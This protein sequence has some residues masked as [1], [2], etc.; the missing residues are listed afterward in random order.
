MVGEAGSRR[1]LLALLAVY[2]ALASVGFGPYITDDHPFRQT[3]TALSASLIHGVGDLWRYELP[4][5]GPP[6]VV[7]F[8]FPLYQG[9]AKA[10]SA[11]AGL[12]LAMAGR[13]VG[14]T[15]LLLCLWPLLRMARLLGVAWPAIVL[16]PVFLAPLYVFWSRAF[17]IET[18]ALLFAL[19]YLSLLLEMLLTRRADALRAAALAASGSLAALV[20]VTTVFPLVLVGAAATA[21]LAWQW[22]R[23]R[24][25]LALPL[26]LALAHLAL[27]AVALAWLRHADA[28]KAAHP[29]AVALTSQALPQWNYGPLSQRIDPAIWFRLVNNSTDMIF[30]LPARLAALKVALLAAFCAVFGFFLWHCD[31]R[32]RRQVLLMAGLFLLPFLI[33]TNLHRIHNYY[34]AANGVF[35]L[36]G[37]G[38]AAHGALEHS[39]R[40][41]RAILSAYLGTLLALCLSCLWYFQHKSSQRGEL[42]EISAALR[43]QTAADAILIISG[44]DWS[45]VIPYQAQRR[46]LMLPTFVNDAMLRNSAAAIRAAGLRVGAYVDCGAAPDRRVP[47]LLA[48]LGLRA[49]GEARKLDGCSLSL[50]GPSGT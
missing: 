5:L 44:Q 48:D 28:I 30:P 16:G 34:Q 50:L 20:K 39:P 35:L 25:P 33:F 13:L 8:E 24:G 32:R 26:H 1:W 47:P 40:R 29:L 15:A 17:L 46:A 49:R 10:L 6:W 45:P 11:G 42:L 37:F 2:L 9:L 38:L 3:Q 23:R 12:P 22:L 21:W 19:I 31:G 43:A 18:T 41:R 36:A 14:M 4:V 27:A 7:P